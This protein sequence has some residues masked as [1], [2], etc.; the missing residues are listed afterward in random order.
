MSSLIFVGVF[1]LKDG[2]RVQLPYTKRS[3][4]QSSREYSHY[5]TAVVCRQPPEL[6]AELRIYSRSNDII[7]PDDTAALIIAKAYI[8]PG[9]TAGDLLLDAL[10]VAPFPGNPASD[11]YDVALPDFLWPLIFG[12]GTV[13]G[14]CGELPEGK[15]SFPVTMSEYVRGSVKQSS[16]L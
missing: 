3:G 15:A 5:S 13:S 4:E 10:N 8:P 12:L 1:A 2:R 16:V 14:P 7:F 11:D 9:D 6:P